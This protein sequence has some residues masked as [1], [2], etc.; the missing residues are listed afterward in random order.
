M[1]RSLR[2][3]L[4]L[5]KELLLY[6]CGVIITRFL[7]LPSY[8]YFIW[9]QG[10]DAVKIREI[11]SGQLTLLGPST[12]LSGVYLGPLW[13]YLGV[14]GFMLGQGNPY[15][16]VGWYVL[17]GVAAAP[18]WWLLTKELFPENKTYQLLCA[19][20]LGCIPGSIT[21]TTFV[22][23]PLLSI[24]LLSASLYCLLRARSSRLFLFS[25]VL[26]AALIFQSEFAYAVFL[27]PAIAC[28]I[29]LIRGRISFLDYFGSGIL[30]LAT[31][32][33]QIVFELRNGFVMTKALVGHLSKAPTASFSSHLLTRVYELI[34]TTG[35]LFVGFEPL[36]KI[37]G[38]SVAVLS[39]VVTFNLFSRKVIVTS[40]QVWKWKVIAL[41]AAA[42][43]LG[44][45]L[46]QGNEGNFFWYYLTPHFI[47]LVPLLLVGL[48]MAEKSRKRPW[49]V[50]LLV[51][52]LIGLSLTHFSRSVLFPD[53]R[54]GLR[55]M[56]QAVAQLFSWSQLDKPPETVF[57]I[58]T[59]NMQTEHYDHLTW[60]MARKQGVSV[61]RTVCTPNDVIWYVLIEPD[62]EEP[63]GRFLPWYKEVKQRGVLVRRQQVGILTLETW[64]QDKT[65]QEK[66]L[67][68]FQHLK[69]FEQILDVKGN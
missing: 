6:C 69:T 21:G 2:R 7:T 13:L 23:N 59:P 26:L 14:P 20:L 62:H 52:I 48:R 54:G 46:W 58:F 56:H 8:A 5:H 24:P 45:L 40:S 28:V 43:Y 25:G 1:M 49:L 64:M 3:N 42:P 18:F 34:T 12:G 33:P 68:P 37:I 65:M 11:V 51:G 63:H 22:W 50:Y 53:N 55:V 19:L 27:L 36:S 66:G 35:S 30:V 38:L 16:L 60:W 67:K 29:P 10:Y 39:I 57:R 61:P 41:L 17:L 32:I 47:L 31:F 9:D 44:F 15:V 4:Q